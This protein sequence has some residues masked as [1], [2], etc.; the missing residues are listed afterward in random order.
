LH[1][2]LATHVGDLAKLGDAGDQLSM[3]TLA[4]W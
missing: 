3:P 4:A 1:D 2:L